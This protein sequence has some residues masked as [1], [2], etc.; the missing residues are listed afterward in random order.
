MEL[1]L[2]AVSGTATKRVPKGGLALPAWSQ[3]SQAGLP[4]A[5][6]GSAGLGS[7]GELGR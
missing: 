4:E 6:G 7:P 2:L 3:K 1:R 5:W